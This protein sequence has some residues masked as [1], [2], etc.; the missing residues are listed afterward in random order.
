MAHTETPKMQIVPKHIAKRLRSSVPKGASVI[1]GTTPVI[2]FGN[3]VT[4]TIATVGLNPSRKEFLNGLGQEL[5]GTKQRFETLRSL[6]VSALEGA[7]NRVLLQVF[8]GCLSYFQ[9]QPYRAWFD[10]LDKIIQRCGASYYDGSACHLD[11]VQWATAPVWG[12]LDR[13]TRRFLL[14]SDVAFFREQLQHSKIQLLLLNGSTVIREFE[15]ALA[16]RLDC[17]GCLSGPRH[18]PS[19]LMKGKT[20]DVCVVGWTMNLQSSHGVT[21]ELRAE[22]AD[23]V[24]HVAQTCRDA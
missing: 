22:L 24:E 18:A 4:A 5:V 17:I 7:D 21:R 10:P 8:D 20:N 19:K 14:D 13:S 11:L 3:C 6:G 2:A 9:H 15:S 23:A 16:I 1:K 12:S